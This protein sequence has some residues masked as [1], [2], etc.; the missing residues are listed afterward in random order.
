[1]IAVF[2]ALSASAR[3]IISP[4]IVGKRAAF[5]QETQPRVLLP[6]LEHLVQ[7]PAQKIHQPLHLVCGPLPVFG[8]KGVDRQIRD[9]EVAGGGDDVVQPFDPRAM[10]P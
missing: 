4:D 3:A 2:L 6:V 7:V 8:G 5:P 1:M 10:P 9:L